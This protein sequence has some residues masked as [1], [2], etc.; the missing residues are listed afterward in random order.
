MV[1]SVALPANAMGPNGL[2]KVSSVWSNNNSANNKT[3]RLRLGA[4][5]HGTAGTVAFTAAATTNLS[6]NDPERLIVNG[7][8]VNAQIG[9]NAGTA[10][11]GGSPSSVFTATVDTSAAV[12]LNFTV[13]LA[14]AA[15]NA[16]LRAFCVEVLHGA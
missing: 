3:F 11:A 9:R 5:G 2:L 8:A 12:D 4:S 7:G 15:D 14:N 1:K 10:G 16:A 13:E 6:Y